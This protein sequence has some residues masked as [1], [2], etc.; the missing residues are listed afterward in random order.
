MINIDTSHSDKNAFQAIETICNNI[1]IEGKFGPFTYK[2]ISSRADLHLMLYFGLSE[3]EKDYCKNILVNCRQNDDSSQFPD[4]VFDKG[5]IEHFHIF[6]SKVT[7]KG[8]MQQKKFVDAEKWIDSH[9]LLDNIINKN[10]SLCDSRYHYDVESEHNSHEFLIH[11]FKNTWEKHIDHL[12]EYKGCKD[13]VF[14]LVD[15]PNRYL[16]E[17]KINEN[18]NDQDLLHC[19]WYVLSRDKTLLQ[20][21][22]S[23]K[24]KV[25]YVIYLSGHYSELIKL[26]SIPHIIKSIPDNLKFVELNVTYTYE[27]QTLNDT[28]RR[29]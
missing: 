16:K 18:L 3:N 25:D 20:Y 14:F 8:S 2:D 17:Q 7:R 29:K 9:M 27:V 23:Q 21:L 6:S 24:N 19:P 11:S 5:L 22:Y 12:N 26:S 15:N 1:D 28:S 13:I 4:F 10:I